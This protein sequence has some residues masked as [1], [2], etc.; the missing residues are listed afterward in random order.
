LRVTDSPRTFL[1]VAAVLVTVVAP[2]APGHVPGPVGV[3]LST[4]ACVTT[5]TGGFTYV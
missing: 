5:V 3:V 4:P 2:D 1:R